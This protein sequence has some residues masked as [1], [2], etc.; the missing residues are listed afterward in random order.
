VRILVTG[1]RGVLARA[2]RAT[3]TAGGHS[4]ILLDQRREPGAAPAGTVETVVADIRTPDGYARHLD[5]VD[6]VV[7]LAGLHGR[8]HMAIFDTD[9]FWSVNVDGT[10]QLYQAAA[11]AGVRHVVLAS[12]MAVYGPIPGAPQRHWVRRTEQ[13][14]TVSH[15]TYSLTKLIGEEI[16][17]FHAAQSAMS[18][19][20]LRFGHFTPTPFADY[21]FR[22]L[23]GGVDVRDAAMAVER[24]IARPDTRARVRRLNIHAPSPFAELSLD[25]LAD[26][27]EEPIRRRYPLV[28]RELEHTGADLSALLWGRSLWPI[29]RARCEIGYRPEWTFDRFADRFCANDER[30]YEPLGWARWPDHGNGTG[31]ADAV[32]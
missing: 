9:E 12:S 7:H 4:L 14:P 8:D 5:G 15:D 3:L 26:D 10:R 28:V 20:V 6:A 1:S 18:T 25:V 30:G 32:A 24:S 31:Q 29:E 2:V 13:T 19:T 11:R 17:E 21:G 23:F 16:A 27:P 22:L